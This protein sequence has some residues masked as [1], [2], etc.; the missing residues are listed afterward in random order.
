MRL[1]S[2]NY[3]PIESARSIDDMALSNFIIKLQAITR[4]VSDALQYALDQQ[5]EDTE[6]V[7]GK[8]SNFK[9]VIVYLLSIECLRDSAVTNLGASKLAPRLI[10]PS[11]V[12]S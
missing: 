7:A 11:K 2:A 10:R 1:P 5:K 9:K 4:F 12:L 6:N 8:M 3:V